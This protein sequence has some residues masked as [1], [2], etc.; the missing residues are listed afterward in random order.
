VAKLID[1]KRSATLPDAL[2]RLNKKVPSHKALEGGFNQ[3][4]GFT[5][6]AEGIRH[7]LMDKPNL[8]TDDARYMLVSCSAFANYLLRLADRAGV[9]LN[10]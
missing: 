9:K 7:A 3:L 2:K 10:R 4:Y 6:D 5:S 8:T 1:G